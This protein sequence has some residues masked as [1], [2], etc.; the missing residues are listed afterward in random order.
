MCYYK[1]DDT[2]N[3]IRNFN[4]LLEHPNKSF[5]DKAS[6]FLALSLLDSGNEPAATKILEEIVQTKST[7]WDQANTILKAL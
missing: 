5:D 3:A 2:S 4:S 7:H 1:L 6:W